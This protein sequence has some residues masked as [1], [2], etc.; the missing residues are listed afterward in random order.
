MCESGAGED[1]EHLLVTYGEFERDR[2]VLG[3]EVSRG[4]DSG[5]LNMEECARR[6][7]CIVG[8]GMVGVSDTVMEEVGDCIMYWIGKWWQKRKDLLY[9]ELMDRF[10]S[11]PLP[12]LWTAGHST[13]TI[14]IIFS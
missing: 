1:V 7:R 6:I 11:P 14:I 10:W 3:D 4:L 9:G 8:N 13:C 5:W 12:P 2:W